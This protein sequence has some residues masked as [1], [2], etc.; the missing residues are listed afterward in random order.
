MF[1]S[2]GDRWP[3]QPW[4]IEPIWPR[5]SQR[6]TI[7]KETTPIPVYYQIT[8]IGPHNTPYENGI[9]YLWLYFPPNY[10]FSP[11]HVH[12]ATPIL[13]PNI[14]PITGQIF[15]LSILHMVCTLLVLLRRYSPSSLYLSG[16]GLVSSTHMDPYHQ[17]YSIVIK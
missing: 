14:C 3:V 8:L 1:V 9:F 5:T 16:T 2:E 10:P 13:H 15:G 12:F 17:E 7:T 11:P 4:T 6:V